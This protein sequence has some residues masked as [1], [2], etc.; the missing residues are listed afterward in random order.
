MEITQSSREPAPYH[1]L[2]YGVTPLGDTG[3]N[4]GHGGFRV[5][6]GQKQQVDGIST[7]LPLGNHAGIGA[8]RQRGFKAETLPLRHQFVNL[9]EHQLSRLDGLALRRKGRQAGGYQVGVDELGDVGRGGDKAPGK[10]GFARA[11]RP[12]DDIDVSCGRG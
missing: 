6:Q 8:A 9:P 5:R 10:G 7:R 12:G 2:R 11:V 1:V 3:G 4:A